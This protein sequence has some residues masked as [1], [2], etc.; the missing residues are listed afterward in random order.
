MSIEVVGVLI[1]FAPGRLRFAALGSLASFPVI[2]FGR[3]G[4]SQPFAAHQNEMPRQTHVERRA[5]LAVHLST[6]CPL[7][8]L[9]RRQR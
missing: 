6:E 8:F 2:T 7:S 5:N 3:Q 4:A 1:M 9:E